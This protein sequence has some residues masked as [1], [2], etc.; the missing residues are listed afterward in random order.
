MKNALTRIFS[1]ILACLLV[2][3][4]SMAVTATETAETVMWV[5]LFLTVTVGRGVLTFE[6]IFEL[7]ATYVNPNA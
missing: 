2:F 4:M 6:Q 5:L 3:G 7:I 1:L